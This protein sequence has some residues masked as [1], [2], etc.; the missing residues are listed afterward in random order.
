[1]IF[2]AGHV[3]IL[4]GRTRLIMVPLALTT[5]VIFFIL[6]RLGSRGQIAP[7]AA[8]RV[9]T[10]VPLLALANVLPHYYLTREIEQTTSVLLIIIG[11]GLFLLLRSSLILIILTAVGGWLLVG[12][13]GAAI[14]AG[15]VGFLI[16]LFTAIGPGSWSSSGHRRGR[17]GGGFGGGGFGGGGFGGGGGSF[18]GGGA[19]GSW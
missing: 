19:S 2:A 12:L 14:L 16:T 10:T 9:A 13:L 15:I 6:W 5:A 18:G 17:Y 3:L 4:E 8:N 7:Q 11:A 1:V